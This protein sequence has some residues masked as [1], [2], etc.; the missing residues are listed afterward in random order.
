MMKGD[1]ILGPPA[2]SLRE[3]VPAERRAVR[4]SVRQSCPHRRFAAPSPGGRGLCILSSLLLCLLLSISIASAQQKPA[5][6]VNKRGVD[7]ST[8]L[9]YAVYNEDVAE[10]RRLIKAGANVS[11]ANNYGATP[12]GLAGEIGNAEIIKLLLD[13]GAN[14]DSPNADGQTALMEVA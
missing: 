2:L 11:L 1:H 10:V 9:Q 4:A 13:A 3:R 5:T 12:M 14:A 8:P 6:D 7:G